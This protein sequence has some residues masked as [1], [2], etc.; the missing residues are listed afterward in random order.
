MQVDMQF[1]GKGSLHC[2]LTLTL[3]LCLKSQ[4][5]FERKVD[6]C[7]SA[8]DAFLAHSFARLVRCG[9]RIML[10]FIKKTTSKKMMFLFF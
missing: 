3:G 8:Q 1:V 10:C 5:L 2:S 7:R 4:S 9:R 6:G